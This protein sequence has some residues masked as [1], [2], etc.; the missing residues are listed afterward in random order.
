MKIL[1]MFPLCV[2]KQLY[3]FKYLYTFIE[4]WSLKQFRQEDYLAAR[5]R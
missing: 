1:L 5:A 3:L 2:I 4:K